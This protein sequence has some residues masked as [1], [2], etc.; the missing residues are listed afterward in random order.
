VNFNA[1][2][3]YRLVPNLH[4]NTGNAVDDESTLATLHGPLVNQDV[5]GNIL[6]EES[7]ERVALSSEKTLCS[8]S[9]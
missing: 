4:L 2:L 5:D 9:T 6:N 3:F 1:C 7:M 8:S